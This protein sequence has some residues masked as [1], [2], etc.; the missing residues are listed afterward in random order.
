MAVR[1]GPG[2]TELTRRGVFFV[3]SAQHRAIVSTADFDAA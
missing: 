2:V 3:S 1:V